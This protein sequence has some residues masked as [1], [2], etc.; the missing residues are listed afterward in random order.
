M[1][2]SAPRRGR[3]VVLEGGESVGKSTVATWLAQRLGARVTHEPGGTRLGGELRR[4]LL[5]SAG[6][7]L[8]IVTEA[9]LMA[10]DRAQHVAEFI[11][12]ALEA[13]H[14]VVCDRYVGS[15]MAYQGYGRGLDLEVVRSLSAVATGG[16]RPDLV[17]LL[18]MDPQRAKA[19]G[20]TGADR[21]EALAPD[22]HSRVRYGYLEMAAADAGLWVVVNADRPIEEVRADVAAA[23]TERLG[24]R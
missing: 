22:F 24:G 9:L 7:R 17:V 14:D 20:V 23:V 19:R 8:D 12:P 3:F 1:A 18:D 11:R 16:L 4:L 10:A 6:G 15:S 2:P 21:F 13:G 5:D